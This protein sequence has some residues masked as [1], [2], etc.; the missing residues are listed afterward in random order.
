MKW[1][2]A[3]PGCLA[4]AAGALTFMHH[5]LG[6]RLPPVLEPHSGFE[7]RLKPGQDTRR[8]DQHVF[9]NSHGMRS[10]EFPAV[11]ASSGELRVMV[12]GDS[13]V[14]GVGFSSHERLATTIVAERLARRL[15]RPVVVGNVAAGS[16]GPGNW[17]A[18]AQEVGFFEADVVVLVA[19]ANDAADVRD[20]PQMHPAPRP[21]P[22]VLVPLVEFVAQQRL[23]WLSAEPVPAPVAARPEALSELRSFL[24]LAQRAVGR[25]RVVLY[26]QVEELAG[27]MLAQ[28][29]ALLASS[30]AAGVE[31]SLPDPRYRRH[32]ESGAHLYHDTVHPTDAGQL[33]L[34][35][36][37]ERE[38]MA[39]VGGT[40]AAGSLSVAHGAS[41][42]ASP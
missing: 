36:V 28:R 1:I 33:L 4:L 14:C 40:P 42:P 5:V 12:F 38:V 29:A 30:R 22:P 26:P 6:M 20:F 16:W 17:L 21:Y 32:L 10:P 35:E 7:Y 37:I 19:S 8:F 34:A 15:G 13:V 41:S 25:V 18:W 2:A 27:P 31:P 39:A 11:K 23:R 9:V 24:S 3:L